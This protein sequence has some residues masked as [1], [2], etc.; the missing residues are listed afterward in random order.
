M[1][2][3]NNNLII[4]RWELLQIDTLQYDQLGNTETVLLN[5]F[6]GVFTLYNIEFTYGGHWFM[7]AMINVSSL[8]VYQFFLRIMIRAILRNSS[9]KIRSMWVHFLAIQ[10]YIILIHYQDISLSRFCIELHIRYC[11]T[12]MHRGGECKFKLTY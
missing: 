1:H 5:V 10:H 2:V 4:D 6:S 3:S 12:T 11:N 7:V 8:A 9:L